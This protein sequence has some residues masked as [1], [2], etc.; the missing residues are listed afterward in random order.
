MPAAQVALWTMQ[1][2]AVLDHAELQ[3]ILEDHL[4]FLIPLAAHV[5]YRLHIYLYHQKW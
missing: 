1:P 4:K 2:L 3:Q 5:L